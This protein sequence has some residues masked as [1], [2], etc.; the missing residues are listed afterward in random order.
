MNRNENIIY[1][2]GIVNDDGC[3]EIPG[4]FLEEGAQLDLAIKVKAGRFEIAMFPSED[5]DQAEC[6][7][8]KDCGISEEEIMRV[9]SA[10]DDC[11]DCPLNDYCREEFADENPNISN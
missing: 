2:K 8:M 9:C 10:H 1:A 11:S 4:V 3:I 6:Q 7:Q 5:E